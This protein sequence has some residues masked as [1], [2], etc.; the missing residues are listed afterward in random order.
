MLKCTGRIEIRNH[1]TD[2]RER[3]FVKTLCDLFND[4]ANEQTLTLKFDVET[5]NAQG[6]TWMLHKLHVVVSRMPIKGEIVVLETWPSGTDRLFALRDFRMLTEKGELLLRATSEWMV[7]DL[8]R[9]RPVRL[10]EVVTEAAKTCEGMIRELG[11]DLN[12]KEIPTDFDSGRRF[13]ATYDNIDFNKHVTQ[14]TYVGWVT[15]SLSFDFLKN[16]ELRELEIV[17]EHEILPD[18]EIYSCPQISGE[19]EEVIVYHRVM[20]KAC[21][22]THCI[23]RTV[24]EKVEYKE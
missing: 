5:L 17:Y 10:P 11:F 4:I 22:K 9:R 19:G 16:H 6:L 13:V 15:N 24:W 23:A 2:L 21:E 20:D 3:L 18:S 12:S 7:I 14:A 1:Y 8:A